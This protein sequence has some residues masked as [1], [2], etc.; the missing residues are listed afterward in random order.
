MPAMRRLHAANIRQF[1]FDRVEHRLVSPVRK[2][3]V[4][5]A[6]LPFPLNR[7]SMHGLEA[8]RFDIFQ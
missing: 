5:M 6:M 8:S 7:E 3:E 2:I 1:A 4:S